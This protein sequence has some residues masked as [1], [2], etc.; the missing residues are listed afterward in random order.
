MIARV[1]AW[2]AAALGAL[3]LAW[4]AGRRDGAV[5]GDLKAHR[6]NDKAHERMTAN[7]KDVARVTDDAARRRKLLDLANRINGD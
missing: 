5:R 1:M 7:E 3:G 2:L 4:M 6:A